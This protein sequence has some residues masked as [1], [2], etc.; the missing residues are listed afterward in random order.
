MKMKRFL[1]ILASGLLIAGCT[2]FEVVQTLPDGTVNTITAKGAPLISRQET[3]DITM[4]NFTED[5]QPYGFSVNR[6]TDE[7]ADQQAEVLKMAIDVLG[8]LA[9]R[10]AVP[11]VPEPV[12]WIDE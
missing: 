12:V 1:V 6:N 7:K 9:M 4:Q 8:K 5:N 2:S 11:V 3:F 10:A